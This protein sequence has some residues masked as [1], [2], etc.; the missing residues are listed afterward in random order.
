MS[1]HSKAITETDRRQTDR[2]TDGKKQTVRKHYFP[3]N[4][5]DNND[6][7][8]MHTVSVKQR[9]ELS[10]I[11]NIVT[12]KQSHSANLGSWFSFYPRQ[13]ASNVMLFMRYTLRIHSSLPPWIKQISW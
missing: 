11:Y 6:L 8:F 5:G 2:P 10:T 7:R 4:A 12:V 9:Q 13:T 3:A 1:R